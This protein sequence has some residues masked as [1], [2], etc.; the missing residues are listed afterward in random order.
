MK[1]VLFAFLALAMVTAAAAPTSARMGDG[2][3]VYVT[4]TGAGHLE[5][6]FG[7][8]AIGGHSVSDRVSSQVL[9]TFDFHVIE[10]YSAD[11]TFW[12]SKCRSCKIKKHFD[13]S[14]K[15]PRKFTV[16]VR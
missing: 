8:L 5:E 15:V 3:T 2:Y 4:I 6:V 10:G 12:G 14:E 9:R 7:T 16:H 13:A 1:K 11:F